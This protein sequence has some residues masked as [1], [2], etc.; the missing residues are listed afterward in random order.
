M[1]GRAGNI[2]DADLFNRTTKTATPISRTMMIIASMTTK[3]VKRLF[4]M[5]IVTS[6]HFRIH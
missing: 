6:V 3:P 2:V 4:I 5:L 1:T